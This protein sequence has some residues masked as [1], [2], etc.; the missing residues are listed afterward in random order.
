[1]SSFAP[2]R[3]NP[4]ALPDGALKQ[5]YDEFRIPGTLPLDL[6]R[7]YNQSIDVPLAR[8]TSPKST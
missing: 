1:M 8:E 5:F 6:T 7:A 2:L 4:V 3:L